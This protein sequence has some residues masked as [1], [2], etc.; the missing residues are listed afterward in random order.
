MAL[1]NRLSTKLGKIELENPLVLASGILGNTAELL[2]RVA[3]AGVGAVTTKSI[4]PVEN[5][6]HPSPNIV[7][8]E[9]GYINAMGLPNPGIEKFVEEVKKFKAKSRKPLIGSVFAPSEEEYAVVA[10]KMDK[11][12]ADIIVTGT[13]VENSEDDVDD[14]SSGAQENAKEAYD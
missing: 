9:C 10:E 11:A 3:K 2:L 13:A 7:E 14:D 6:G 12:G 5:K 4:G 8:V 1:T